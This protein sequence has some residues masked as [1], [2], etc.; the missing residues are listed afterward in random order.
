MRKHTSL[1]SQFR[2]GG[3]GR[4]EVI[5]DRLHLGTRCDRSDTQDRDYEASQF[6]FLLITPLR[7]LSIPA[8]VTQLCQDFV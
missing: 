3:D 2:P 1:D 8:V 7:R 5:D 4:R 6:H